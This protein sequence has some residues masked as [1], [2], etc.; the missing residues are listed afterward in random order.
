MA[1]SDDTLVT[2]GIVGAVAFFAY[3]WWK[4]HCPSGTFF[5]CF[6]PGQ[7]SLWACL[8]NLNFGTGQ[9]APGLLPMGAGGTPGG[10]G[11]IPGGSTGTGAPVPSTTPQLP[12]LPGGGQGTWMCINQTDYSV[13]GPVDAAGN[14]PPGYAPGLVVNATGSATG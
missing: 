11:G 7:N 9:G 6:C 5:D 2:L 8:T 3:Q 14:C 13:G 1:K 12:S 10:Q 4:Q